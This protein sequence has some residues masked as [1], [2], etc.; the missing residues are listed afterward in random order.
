MA[1]VLPPHRE[2][3]EAHFLKLM[4]EEIENGGYT[5]GS[6]FRHESML[7]VFRKFRIVYGP[8]YSDRFLKMKVKQL[9]KR[10]QEFSELMSQDEIYWNKQNNV[11]YGNM[12]LLSEKYKV[13]KT[14]VSTVYDFP[15][16]Y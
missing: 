11:V 6:T 14:F 7:Y 8:I 16:I 3:G 12:K 10:Y 4:A 1:Y 9:K 5:P 2:H 15:L 13:N